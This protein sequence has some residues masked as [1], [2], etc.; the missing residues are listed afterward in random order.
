[1]NSTRPCNVTRLAAAGTAACGAI[2]P[3]RRRPL[4]QF[5]GGLPEMRKS[6]LLVVLLVCATAAAAESKGPPIGTSEKVYALAPENQEVRGLALD[7]VSP[8]APRL[9]VLDRSGK[10]FAYQ[11]PQDP[12]AGDDTLK[13]LRTYPLPREPKQRRLA[14]PRSLA[15][16]RENGRDVVYFLNWELWEK[17]YDDDEVKTKGRSHLWR[18]DLDDGTAASANLSLYPL[19]IGDR[20]LTAVACDRGEI[21]VAYDASGYA[22]SDLRARRGIVRLKW[23]NPLHEKPVFLQFL[24]DSG[25]AAA[26]GLAA[27]T[28]DDAHYLWATVGNRQIYCAEA[29]AGRGLFFFDRPGTVP[30]FAP[31]KMGLSPSMQAH[32]GRPAWGLCYGRRALWVPEHRPGA[33]CVHRVNVTENLD[34]PAVGPKILRHLVMTIHSKPEVRSDHA[35]R[36]YHNYSRPYD[37]AAVPS[38]GIWPRTERIADLS[39]QGRG[40]VKRYSVDPAGDASIRQFMQGVEYPDGPSQ[41]HASQYEIDLWTRPCHKF[42]YPHRVNRNTRALKGTN[43][44]ADDPE[45]F[46][47]S[48]RQTYEAF[49]QRVKAHIQEKYGVPADMENPYWATRNALEYIQD[50]YYYPN[51]A[52]A[53]PAAVDYARKHYDANPGNM[54]IALS[55]RKYDKSQI[56]ACSGTSVMLSGAM[57]YLGFPARWVG[58]GTQRPPEAW[59][60]NG[61]GLLDPDETAPC[62]N[63]HRFT[64][65]WLGEHYGWMSFDGTPSKP[66]LNDYD[67]P[68][69]LQTQ[70]RYMSRIAASHPHNRTIVFNL[71]SAL[72]RPLYRDFLYDEKLAVDNNCGGDQR[73]NLQ[74]RFDKPE[75]WK[76]SSDH[77]A[78]KNLC[79]I[80]KIALS[81]PKNRTVVTWRLQ[82]PWNLDPEATLSV[83]L[84][85]ID[86]A[87]DTAEDV[88]TLAESIPC[89][90]RTATVDLSPYAA[91]HLRLILRKDG[92]SETGGE[93]QAF[94]R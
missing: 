8:A 69:P 70:W 64:Q 85:E 81:G 80:D 59:D 40:A 2:G 9:F 84:Q 47:L 21:L 42:V 3:T 34:A 16:A 20:E 90:Q 13:L 49:F 29:A 15:F 50:N 62:T 72:F 68:P 22:D 12:K 63:G 58:T 86:P 24:P 79:W 17:S 75:L 48:D 52:K 25:T 54:K 27:M 94:D 67:P 65:V 45:L 26:H 43:Y 92:D 74:G 76:E 35:G 11:L 14:S 1:M 30:I 55:G 39:K 91:K 57:R 66:D 31:A 38:Q 19:R 44:L 18:L 71:G 36:V 89:R 83:V 60:A 4:N 61:N 78:V 10:I 88:A 28:L 51:R 46:N 53:K 6:A 32:E 87:T 23:G 73:Y 33:D 93:S 37:T 7:D 77:I 41:V 56:I 82:G 5:V